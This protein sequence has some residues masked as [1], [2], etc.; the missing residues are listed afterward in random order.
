M[1]WNGFIFLNHTSLYEYK[2]NG[3]VSECNFSIDEFKN[4]S[5]FNSKRENQG[6]KN[7]LVFDF[8]Y[9]VVND[10]WTLW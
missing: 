5:L 9:F 8:S 10:L 6:S 2:D 7:F 4:S 3:Q 1:S